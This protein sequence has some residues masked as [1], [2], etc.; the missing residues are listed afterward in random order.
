MPC[1]MSD[2]RPSERYVIRRGLGSLGAFRAGVA[3]AGFVLGPAIGGFM[4]DLSPKAPFVVAACF[5]IANALYGLLVLP[6]SLPRT[7]RT[8]FSWKRA[9]PIGALVL[10][11]RHPELTGLAGVAFLSN[12]AQVSLPTTVVLYLTHRFGWSATQTG[13][14]LTVEG[15]GGPKAVDVH[16][17]PPHTLI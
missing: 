7:C 16:G 11:R 13:V 9:N 3:G 8:G 17:L 6:E 15:D 12:L 5:S 2:S 14:T 1:A 10:L 4:G